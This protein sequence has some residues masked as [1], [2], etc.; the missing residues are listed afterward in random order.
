MDFSKLRI[1]ISN[2]D[3]IEAEGIKLL[4]RFVRRFTQSVWVCAPATNQSAKSHSLTLDRPVRVDPLGNNRFAVHGTPADSVLIGIQ[5][6][7]KDCRPDF[8][9]SGVNDGLN[10]ADDSAYSGTMAV[11]REAA[12]RGVRSISFSQKMARNGIRSWRAAEESLPTLIPYLF[13]IGTPSGV[14][15]NINFPDVLKRTY[16]FKIVRQ[17]QY[18]VNQAVTAVETSA[19]QHLYRLGAVRQDHPDAPDTDLGALAEGNVAITP[20]K[21]DS[22]DY[23]TLAKIPRYS[24]PAVQVRQSA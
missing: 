22:T 8:V 3:G 17:G 19:G 21:I 9:F 20:L 1:L 5:N 15:L 24:Q 23:E 16:D 4:E 18:E 10:A 7:M 14:F 2:D 11:A 13:N 6:Y 12:I